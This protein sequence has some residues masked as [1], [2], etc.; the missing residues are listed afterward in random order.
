[1]RTGLIH[2]FSDSLDTARG[3]LIWDDWLD[4]YV[5]AM[6]MHRTG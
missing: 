3:A 2:G 5:H 1:M 4:S 6:R